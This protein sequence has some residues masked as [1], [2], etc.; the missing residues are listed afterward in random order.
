VHSQGIPRRI[1]VISD[2]ILLF[3]YGEG[4]H[5]IDV[6]LTQVVLQELE[7]TG[8]L[9]APPSRGKGPAEPPPR[10]P[11]GLENDLKA[12]EEALANRERQL[13]EQRQV[14]NDEY[15]LLRELYAVRQAEAGFDEEP[16]P[17]AKVERAPAGRWQRLRQ[18]IVNRAKPVF[19]D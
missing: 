6:D 2:A 7:A 19:G 13:T 10:T 5:A 14:L 11:A 15:R 12:R 4:K 1:N 9:A 17:D 16:A 18:E 3:G 8:V